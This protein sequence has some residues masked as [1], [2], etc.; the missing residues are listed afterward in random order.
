[1]DPN[2]DNPIIRFT[3][4]WWAIWT[5]LIFAVL[6]AAVS[7]AAASPG[8]SPTRRVRG[9]PMSCLKLIENRFSAAGLA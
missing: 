3:T 1:M 7:A 9:W 8:G 6:L 5:F 4:F 2:R